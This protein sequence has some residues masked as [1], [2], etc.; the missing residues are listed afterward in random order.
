LAIVTTF[1]AV[2]LTA[3]TLTDGVLIVAVFGVADGALVETL[4]ADV[5]AALPVLVLTAGVDTATFALVGVAAV[6]LAG[7]AAAGLLVTTGVLV[8]DFGV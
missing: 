4:T 1:F 3:A 6:L 8:P 5:E 7:V 2:T